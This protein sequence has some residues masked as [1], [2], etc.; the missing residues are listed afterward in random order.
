[1]N[2]QEKIEGTN[3]HVLSK[4]PYSKPELTVFGKVSELTAPPS[5]D[6]DP[7]NPSSPNY[8]DDTES[9]EPIEG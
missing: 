8:Q 4:K 6:E 3:T 1:M 9:G 7:N 5:R 2:Q